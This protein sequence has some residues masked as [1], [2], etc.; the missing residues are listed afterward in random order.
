MS[1]ANDTFTGSDGTTLQ[2]HT[3]DSSHTW[4]KQTG[5]DM[6]LNTNTVYNTNFTLTGYYSSAVPAGVDYDVVGTVKVA[7][8]S[9][10]SCGVLGRMSTSATTFYSARYKSNPR[11]EL[12]KYIAGAATLLGSYDAAG[13]RPSSAAKTV[14]LE[15]RDATKKVY[16]SG[17]ERIS[18]A[19]NDITAAG[20]PGLGHGAGGNDPWTESWLDDWSATDAVGGGGAVIPVFMNQYRQRW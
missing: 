2:S 16:I 14:K 10:N 20:R 4:T 7:T 6:Q 1:F 9:K 13:D 19:D 11:W 5:S 18:S 3:S 8:S 17:V 12:N 15:I